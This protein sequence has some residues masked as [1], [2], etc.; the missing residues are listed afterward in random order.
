MTSI[1]ATPA[2]QRP[3][4]IR[5]SILGAAVLSL[6]AAAGAA[7]GRPP[8]FELIGQA[9]LAIQIHL[10]AVVLALGVGAWQLL[11]PKGTTAHRALGWTWSL[12][13]MAAALSSF[14]IRTV[15]DGW[16]SPIHLLSVITLVGLPTAIWAAHRHDVRRHS[17]IMTSVYLG[18]MIV[19]GGFAFLPGRLLWNVFFS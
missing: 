18:G 17:R 8:R 19:A 12:A 4:A 2:P 1:Q 15:I 6:T 3:W 9:G 5:L 13:M 16:F 7:T 10:A 11:G 14:F